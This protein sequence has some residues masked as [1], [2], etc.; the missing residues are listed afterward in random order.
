MSL[1]LSIP[2]RLGQIMT[3]ALSEAIA[4]LGFVLRLVGFSLSQVAPFYLA[5]ILLRPF[6]NPR[7]SSAV[8]V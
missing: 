6:F 8:Q 1:G 4:L 7:S 3:F 5:G 2:G